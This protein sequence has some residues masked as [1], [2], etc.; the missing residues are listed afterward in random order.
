MG[1]FAR[2]FTVSASLLRPAFF[3]RV[4][5]PF[6]AAVNCSKGKTNKASMSASVPRASSSFFIGLV[7]HITSAGDQ[8]VE[9]IHHFPHTTSHE[10]ATVRCQNFR[11]GCRRVL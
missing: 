10:R 11:A 2:A 9:L 1:G 6:R 3:R 8:N 7:C 5:K 4:A